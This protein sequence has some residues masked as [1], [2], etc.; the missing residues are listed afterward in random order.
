MIFYLTYKEELEQ[1]NAALFWGLM[2]LVL[3]IALAILLVLCCC[4]VP[5]CWCYAGE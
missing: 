1:K 4:C 5:G 3:A 2:G